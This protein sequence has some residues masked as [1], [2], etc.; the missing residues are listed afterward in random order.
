RGPGAPAPALP[1][2]AGKQVLKPNRARCCR[3]DRLSSRP[4]GRL[5]GLLA[6]M[7]LATLVAG[8]VV[9]T[10]S[11]AREDVVGDIDAPALDG[12][13]KW[14]NSPPLTLASLKGKVVLIDFWEYTCVNCVRTLPYLKA[15]HERYADKGLVII[16][17]HTPE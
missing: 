16:G 2:R 8:F 14:L 6:A 17:V 5:A 13:V 4:S 9:P 10:P 1:R 7:A 3:S 11:A 15:W 12:G